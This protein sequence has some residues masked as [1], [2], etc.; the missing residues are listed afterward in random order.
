MQQAVIFG[1]GKIARGFVGHLLHVSGIPFTFIEKNPDLVRQINLRGHYH[2][3]VMGDPSQSVEIGN[4]RAI[5][6]DDYE[7]AAAAW[8]SASVAFTCVGGKNLS[9]LATHL[10]VIFSK[11]AALI[12]GTTNLITCE[13]W[14]EPASLLRTRMVELISPDAV[15]AFNNRFG[16]SEAVIMRSAVEPTAEEL[17]HDPLWVS[18]QNFWE[19]PVDRARIV[20]EPVAITGVRYIDGFAG[21][22]ERKFY[23]YNAANG[24]TAFLGYLRGHRTIYEAAVDPLIME[25]LQHIYEETGRAL[26]AK[27][28]IPIESQM[29]F[30]ASSLRKLQDH[31]IV[32]YIE[33]NAR[34]PIRKLGPDDRLVGSAR[35]VM[36]HGITPHYLARSIAAA[37]HYAEPTDPGALELKSLLSH[38]GIDGVLSQVCQID[39]YSDLGVLVK[40]SEQTLR[41]EGILR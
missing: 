21:Y 10:A 7:S 15:D 35:L 29:E 40:Q 2:V 1:A 6:L 28:G 33:R 41:Q 20:G 11:R 14:K 26:A 9:E 39:P 31:N 32:D 5:C 27:H 18:V 12:S 16:I 25:A 3:E 38:E 36:A 13:N 37:I 19:L 22:L 17:A 34:D 24:T 23:T 4:A 30:A 8:A